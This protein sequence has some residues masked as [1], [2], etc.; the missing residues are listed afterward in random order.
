VDVKNGFRRGIPSF[1]RL[2][3]RDWKTLIAVDFCGYLLSSIWVFII[4]WVVFI[5]IISTLQYAK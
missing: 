5:V 1:T 3:L 4:I 2:P